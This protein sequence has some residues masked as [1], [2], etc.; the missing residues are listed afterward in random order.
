[1]TR[2]EKW[3]EKCR[4]PRNCFLQ[5]WSKLLMKIKDQ[6]YLPHHSEKI[7]SKKRVC[8]EDD[9][10]ILLIYLWWQL[11]GNLK[12]FIIGLFLSSTVQNSMNCFVKY[13]PV[14]SQKL[15]YLVFCS[16][17]DRGN[18]SQMTRTLYASYRGSFLSCMGNKKKVI[19]WLVRSR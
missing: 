3:T 11:P 12:T 8:Q 16:H 15:W 13:C 14:L 19:Y 7:N 17:S 1:M 4:F 6:V 9:S 10:S 18:R 5:Y 2:Q